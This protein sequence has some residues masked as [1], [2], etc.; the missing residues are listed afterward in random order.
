[1]GGDYNTAFLQG[2]QLKVWVKPRPPF[3]LSLSKG[4]RGEEKRFDK[5]T[6]NG[7]TPHTFNC[8]LLQ[9]ARN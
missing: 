2:A 5:L 9:G 3:A 6:A 7:E 8:T 4:S 1:M